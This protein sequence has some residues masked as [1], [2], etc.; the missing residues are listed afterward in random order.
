MRPISGKSWRSI[1]GAVV[2][3]FLVSGLGP[4]WLPAELEAA[5]TV[6]DSEKQLAGPDTNRQVN[7]PWPR[8][9][10]RDRSDVQPPALDCGDDPCYFAGEHY[11][12][13]FTAWAT[14]VEVTIR[15]PSHP[16]VDGD[17][18]YVLLSVWDNAGRYDQIGF[19]SCPTQYVE[20]GGATAF[21]GLTYSTT[22]FCAHNFDFDPG[23][24][25]LA[26]GVRYTFRMTLGGGFLTFQAWSFGRTIWGPFQRP[27][28]ATQFELD[29][30]YS[31]EGQSY[32]NFENYEEVHELAG[33]QNVPVWSFAFE[34][35]K[36]NGAPLTSDWWEFKTGGAPAQIRLLIS[37][38]D[39]TIAN[40]FFSI[41]MNAGVFG[42]YRGT[43]QSSWTGIVPQ[44]YSTSCPP[45]CFVQLSVTRLPAGWAASLF[46]SGGV[47]TF[48]F[49]ITLT[50]PSTAAL[51]VYEVEIRAN[52]PERAQW[53]NVLMR[54]NV[55]RPPIG[56]CV[57]FGS[58]I[59]T[60]TGNLP[61]QSLSVGQQVMSYDHQTLTMV[62]ATLEGFT[63]S[64][65]DV[66]LVINN[67][68]LQITVDSQPIYY[69]NST[70]EGYMIHPQQMQYGGLL[71]NPVTNSWTI[72]LKMDFVPGQVTVFDLAP[73][74]V[75]GGTFI[76]NGYDVMR[77]T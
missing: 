33:E 2:L 59:L 21:W 19:S 40:H 13:W 58:P 73:S 63:Q 47:P 66:I 36:A 68:L 14:S 5:S 55:W 28:T 9:V 18:F 72:L 17:F 22:D 37:G 60:P 23:A 74:L 31:C 38:D 53:T 3:L 52:N 26:E 61:V 12:P 6:R 27:T 7:H 11:D 16:P 70:F 57:A 20:C 29:E 45:S 8:R 71:F 44:L 54:I 4:Q 30:S 69:R 76:V 49:T 42:V 35:V 24:L 51:G 50:I 62:V 34:D 32:G 15:T 75:G 64:T 1:A 46:P 39:M 77:K 43:T 25:I 67:G 56:G 48:T 41:S 10:G 65:D